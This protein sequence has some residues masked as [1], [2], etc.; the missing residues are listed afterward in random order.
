MF[1]S[2][3]VIMI[4]P[5]CMYTNTFSAHPVITIYPTLFVCPVVLAT[6]KTAKISQMWSQI[7]W[8]YLFFPCGAF[9]IKI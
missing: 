8:E 3:L 6:M 5:P 4:N 9:E 2:A 1:L 7:S